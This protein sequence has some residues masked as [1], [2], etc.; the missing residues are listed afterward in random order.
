MAGGLALVLGSEGPLSFFGLPGRPT[1]SRTA[2]HDALGLGP[3]HPKE[4]YAPER[5]ERPSEKG[6]KASRSCPSGAATRRKEGFSTPFGWLMGVALGTRSA[7]LGSLGR[8]VLGNAQRLT[9]PKQPPRSCAQRF[10]LWH[11]TAADKVSIEEARR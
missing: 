5:V 4:I 8:G 11:H 3:V 2:E 1:I 10:A 9:T 6:L 7:F